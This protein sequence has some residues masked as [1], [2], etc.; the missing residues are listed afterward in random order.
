MNHLDTDLLDQLADYML[1]PDGEPEHLHR[2][3]FSVTPDGTLTADISALSEIGQLLA[4]RAM[5]AWTEVI[6][7]RFKLV[8]SNDA[9]ITFTDVHDNARATVS[10]KDGKIISAL[11]NVPATRI[12]ESEGSVVS[13]AFT[14]FVHEI[15]HALGLRHPGSYNSPYVYGEDNL[16]SND[17]WQTTVMSYF[18]QTSNTDVNAS[19]ARAVTP[20]IAD[21]IAMHDLYGTP[22]LR[23]GDT[24]YGV[25]S[26]LGGHLGQIFADWT[27]GNLAAAVTLTLF[28]SGGT[29]TLDLRADTHNQHVVL[30]PETASDVY[31]LVGNLVIARNTVIENYVAGS[32]NDTITGNSA[33]NI[34]EGGAGADTL[35]GAAGNDTAAYT[36]SDA[37]V[38]VNLA[39]GTATGGHAEGDNLTSIENLIGSAHDDTLTGDT[40]NNLFEGGPGADALDG[41]TGTDT[42]DYT[43]SDAPVTIDLGAD[44][45]IGGHAEGDT[46]SNIENLL[47]SRHND[48]LAGNA[49]AN[50]LNGGPGIDRVSYSSSNAAVTVNLETNDVR[51]GYA[52]GDVLDSIENITGSTHD[53]TL[54]GDV[55]NNVLEGG[56]GADVLNGGDGID[57]ASYAGS[58]SRVDVRL[59]G[60]VVNHG[61]ATGDTLSSIENLIGSAHN[62]VLAGNG[63]ANTLTGNA[64][65]DLLWGSSGDDLLIGGAGADRLVGGN[66]DDTASYVGSAEGVTVRLHGL[67]AAGGDAQGDTFPYMVDIAYTD[68]DG[69]RQTDTLPDVENLTGSS[70]NDILAGDRRD[71]VIDGG[72]GDDILYGGPGGGDDLMYGGVGNDQLFGGQGDDTL[73]GGSG[74]D[75]LVGGMGADVYVFNPFDGSDTVTDFAS[76][77]DKIN[78]TAF[79][80]E[81]LDDVTLSTGDGGVTLDLSDIGGGTILLADLTTAPDA[82]DFLI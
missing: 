39:D 49:D 27:S 79:D 54:V 57:T 18:S 56:P 78:L 21:I 11:I 74:D 9:H 29:D 65:N 50:Q 67:S 58:N 82:G 16:F 66:G 68:V 28:D 6:G 70:H 45:A 4:R 75:R 60:T 36:G 46:L 23:A 13:P 72:A 5:T 37:A 24:V 8:E 38:T 61:D 62:D 31:G 42:A 47:G 77:T 22:A 48:M 44:V 51:G 3:A 64:G 33:N 1:A 19:Y 32:G 20:M 12:N 43:S 14:A 80:I 69:V 52:E 59:S 7:I 15:G 63:L 55:G 53:D 40:G 10:S 26:N 34:L 41:A 30:Q 76:G 2:I 17:S 35:D 25:G 73:S 81:S 71:N